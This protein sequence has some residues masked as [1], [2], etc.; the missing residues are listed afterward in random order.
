MIYSEGRAAR[1]CGGT[2]CANCVTVFSLVESIRAFSKYNYV[3]RTSS[4]TGQKRSHDP[5][6]N[7]HAPI[8]DDGRVTSATLHHSRQ[9]SPRRS[10]SEEEKRSSSDEQPPTILEL[11]LKTQND[12]AWR[13]TTRGMHEDVYADGK[14]VNCE[15]VWPRS[16]LMGRRSLGNNPGA[17]SDLHHLF[18]T[19]VAVN[20]ARAN[21]PFGEVEDTVAEWWNDAPAGRRRPQTAGGAV[22][23]P[24][25]IGAVP[26]DKDRWSELDRKRGLFEP[27]ELGYVGRTWVVIEFR[28]DH[29]Y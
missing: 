7:R 3:S 29:D 16:L 12:A 18:P 24:P 27:P 14:G 25:E 8:P 26:A 20:N 19:G 9:Q 21:W 13:E 10:S 22:A 6:V 17:A 15:H 1:G 4:S 2:P 23:D 28:H 11:S 5:H